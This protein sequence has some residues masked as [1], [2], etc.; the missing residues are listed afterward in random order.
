RKVTALLL[1]TLAGPTAGPAGVPARLLPRSALRPPPPAAPG[2]PDVV[3][4][5]NEEAL[6]AI[7]ADRTPPPKAARNLAMVHAAVYDAVNSVAPTHRA[8]YTEARPRP[9]CSADLAAAIAAH[10]VLV[11]LYPGRARCFDDAL[12]RCCSDIP[13]AGRGAA[14][15]VG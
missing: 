13:A 3:I 8:Y 6:R 1:L 9:G 11:S 2:R 10:R 15:E 5:W 7:R 4:L 14:L 12:D